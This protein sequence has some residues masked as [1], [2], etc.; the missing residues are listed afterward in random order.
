MRY[1][2]DYTSYHPVRLYPDESRCPKC[3]EALK[4]SYNGV[5]Y[6]AGLKERLEIAYEVHHC[7][8]AACPQVFPQFLRSRVL[9]K[10]EYGLDVIAFVG[11]RRLKDHRTFPAIGEI[12]RQDYHLQIS[13]REVEYLFTQYLA[14]VATPISQDP[15]RLAKLKQQG[16]IILSLD[17]AQPE[18][19]RESLWIFRDVLSGEILQGFS[20]LSINAAALITVLEE[21]QGLGVPITGVISDGQNIIVE[22]VAKAL[23]GVPH[24]LCQFHFLKDLAKPVTALDRELGGDLRQQLRGLNAFE[25]VT[26]PSRPNGPESPEIKAPKSVTLGAGAPPPAPGPGRPRLHVRLR[27]ADTLAEEQIVRQVCE[28]VRAILT[29]SGRY[30]LEAPGADTHRLMADVA[31]TLHDALKKTPRCSPANSRSTSEAR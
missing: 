22:A 21:I 6:V 16:R 23:P 4:R 19:D 28:I 27:A 14:L 1:A 2:R 10:Y 11:H 15:A 9:P 17:A 12:L 5:R 20:R 26:D 13:D 7:G 18:A 31:R 25:K 24:Q 29:K 8:R 3:G 30:P